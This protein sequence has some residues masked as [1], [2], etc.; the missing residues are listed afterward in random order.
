MCF[1][2]WKN[3]SLFFKILPNYMLM[4]FQKITILPKA[5]YNLPG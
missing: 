3:S 1:N 2:I 4:K 5:F